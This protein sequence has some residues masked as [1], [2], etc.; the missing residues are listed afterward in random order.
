MMRKLRSMHPHMQTVMD[1]LKAKPDSRINDLARLYDIPEAT[2]RG[3]WRNQKRRLQE[4]I[5]LAAVINSIDKNKI[6]EQS[7]CSPW[8]GRT[9]SYS[10]P[11]PKKVGSFFI[12]DEGLR[13]AVIGDM[14]VKPDIDL[15]YCERIG[16]YMAH[17]RPDVIVCIG[18]FSDMPSLSFWEEPGSKAYNLQ[19]YK[20]DILAVHHGMKAMMTPIQKAMREYNWNPRLVMTMGNHEDRITRTLEKIPKLD[21]TIG[22]PDLEYERW[23][24]EVHAFLKPVIIGGIAFCHYFCSGAMG[25]PISS[26]RAILTKKHQSSVCGH[27]QGRDLAFG[28][29]GD[30]KQ[31]ISIICGSTYEHDEKY[32][33]HQTNNHWRGL[34][35]LNNVVDG[36]FEELAVSLAYLRRKYGA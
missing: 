30:G 19:N 27:L 24:W 5:D 20:A 8:T 15:G 29:R 21:G 17:K 26:A 12:P 2:I 32:L 1:I 36:E 35:L 3:V 22:L 11:T 7:D 31:I 18:D 25:R 28:S 13:I 33:N 23:G 4:D 10:E 16:R 34:Y 9:P 6:P 14:Q